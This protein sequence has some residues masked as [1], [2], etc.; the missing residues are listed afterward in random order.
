MAKRKVNHA[1]EAARSEQQKLLDS[2]YGSEDSQRPTAKRPALFTTAEKAALEDPE[3]PAAPKLAVKVS[4]QGH[5]S[6]FSD[7][8][9]TPWVEATSS[10]EFQG[11]K[12]ES[13]S[14]NHGEHR[15]TAPPPNRSFKRHRVAP[16]DIFKG[17]QKPRK[18]YPNHTDYIDD[19][20]MEHVSELRYNVTAVEEENAALKERIAV[21]EEKT[22][23]LEAEDV[24]YYDTIDEAEEEELV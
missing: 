13:P 22:A 1:Q 6:W 9:S 20:L 3:P 5:S 8:R 23:V 10:P 7:P 12:S 4:L 11:Q 24:E 2:G 15:A 17:V 19:L 14:L 18:A 21:L 16:V